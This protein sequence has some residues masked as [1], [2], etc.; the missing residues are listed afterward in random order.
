M[1]PA[2]AATALEALELTGVDIQ[3]VMKFF[4]TPECPFKLSSLRE[5]VV[6]GIGTWNF[7]N[8]VGRI[9]EEAASSIETLIWLRPWIEH[10][11]TGLE[12]EPPVDSRKL[13]SLRILVFILTICEEQYD[14]LC[15]LLQLVQVPENLERLVIV[16]DDTY[17]IPI[18]GA[19]TYDIDNGLHKYFGQLG[20]L[21]SIRIHL[22][23]ENLSR[24]DEIELETDAKLRAQFP[25]LDAT[26]KL[27][28]SLGNWENPE[29][30]A[31][32]L[33]RNE[34]HNEIGR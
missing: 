4:D 26:G 14:H 7:L 29:D 16:I 28:V 31:K 25:T 30:C 2:E 23:M 5:L 19:F 8:G 6:A 17:N 22:I 15:D 12:I 10:N 1:R 3:K 27:S 18:F 21:R 34:R 33:A 24:V 32:A 9:L 20:K 11:L 13:K